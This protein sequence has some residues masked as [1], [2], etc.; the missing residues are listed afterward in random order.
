VG[1]R[2]V[3]VKKVKAIVRVRVEK[4]VRV[5]VRHRKVFQRRRKER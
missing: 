3:L 1:V 5:G 2:K 4:V